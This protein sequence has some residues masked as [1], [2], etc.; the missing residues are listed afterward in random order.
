LRELAL[1]RPALKLYQDRNHVRHI[2]YLPNLLSSLRISLAPGMLGA[3][4]SNSKT[5]FLILLGFAVVSDALDGFLARQLKVE[6]DMGRRLDRWGDA[7]TM[8]FGAVGFYFLW[9]LS[10]EMEWQATLLA[11]LGYA[12]IGYDRLVRRLDHEKVSAWWERVLVLLVPLSL[13]P[14]ILEFSP[15]PFRAAAVLQAILA[16]KTQ[17]AGRAPPQDEPTAESLSATQEQARISAK[18]VTSSASET[19]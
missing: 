12:V 18:D 13:I 7:L 16:L 14:L 8:A 11:L 19:V 1:P 4:Y 2:P 9:P 3:A 17:I 15:W 10:F 5:G 6:S